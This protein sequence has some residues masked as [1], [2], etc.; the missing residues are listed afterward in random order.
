MKQWVLLG[1]FGEQWEMRNVVLVDIVCRGLVVKS[2]LHSLSGEVLDH[3][4]I[5]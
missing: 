1:S 4:I 2:S 3:P 5:I